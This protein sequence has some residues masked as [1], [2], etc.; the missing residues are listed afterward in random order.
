MNSPEEEVLENRSYIIYPWYSHHLPTSY[1][2]FH[3]LEDRNDGKEAPITSCGRC[4]TWLKPYGRVIQGRPNILF[5]VMA[6]YSSHPEL[7]PYYLTANPISWINPYLG[8]ITFC[9]HNS[10]HAVERAMFLFDFWSLLI[11]I[12]NAHSKL[13]CSHNFLKDLELILRYGIREVM[14]PGGAAHLQLAIISFQCWRTV[15]ILLK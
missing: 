2:C 11:Q 6:S 12:S 8:A 10:S 15:T 1:T 14:Y 7:G 9:V 4:R 5:H 3:S 13:F